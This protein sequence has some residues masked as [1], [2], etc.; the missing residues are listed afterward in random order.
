MRLRDLLRIPQKHRRTGSEVRREAN[1]VE[2]ARVDLVA[3]PHSRP[4]LRI[5]Y[6]TL[7]LANTCPF[8]LKKPGTQRYVYKCI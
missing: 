8:D 2:A 3:L 1:P 4:N 6:R 7:D 5:E